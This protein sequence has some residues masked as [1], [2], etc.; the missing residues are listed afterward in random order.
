MNSRPKC[1]PPSLVLA[2]LLLFC[3]S[4]D[5]F[6]QQAQLAW[7]PDTSPAAGYKVYYGQSSGNYT[8]NIDA[9][10]NTT[11]T[12]QNLSGPTY[13]VAVTAYDSGGNQSGFSPE[14]VMDSF[15]ASAG[16]GGYDIPGRK[17]FS[18]PGSKP[19]LYD[20][21]GYRLQGRQCHGRR[22]IC[23]RS[24]AAIHFPMSRPTTRSPRL[25]PQIHILS[26]PLPAQT[27]PSLL[28]ARSR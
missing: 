3:F 11:Y 26:R 8:S 6:A 7:N 1:F 28:R 25:L 15:T 16:S 20:H 24:H 19:N 5:A 9:G 10:N 12:L 4:L 17:F 18:D 23:R 2:F 22:H 27:V 21:T 13:F 14:L